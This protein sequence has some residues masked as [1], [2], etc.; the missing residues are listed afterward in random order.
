MTD[1]QS[2]NDAI[3]DQYCLMR[4]C[5]GDLVQIAQ[6]ARTMGQDRLAT[7]I[8]Q[9]AADIVRSAECVSQAHGNEIYERARTAD[10]SSRAMLSA[11]LLSL[12][13]PTDKVPA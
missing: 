3:H 6:A 11:A 1:K 12:I 10:A 5:S 13:R 4:D 7:E 8:S 2:P 9:I